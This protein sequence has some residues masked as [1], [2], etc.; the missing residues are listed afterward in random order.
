MEMSKIA[1]PKIMITFENLLWA[2]SPSNWTFNTTYF[3]STLFVVI[4]VEKFDDQLNQKIQR[5]FSMDV[6]KQ[7]SKDLHGLA[8]DCVDEIKTEIRK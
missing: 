6:I 2:Q 5:D 8:R 7:R 3:H 4:V 1:K